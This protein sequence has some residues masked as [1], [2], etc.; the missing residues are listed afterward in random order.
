[1][2]FA[3]IKM[4][5]EKAY[6]LPVGDIH[7]GDKA[8]KKVGKEKLKAN[9]DWLEEHKDHAFGVIMGDVFN[10]AGRDT[11][12]TP[13][14][15]DSDEYYE[16]EAFF[17]PYAHLFVGAVRGNHEDRL[18]NMYGFDPL[19]LFCNHLNIPYFG[20]AALL[21]IQVGKRPDSNWFWNSYY[22]MV[23]HT[24]GGGGS[25]G[26]A[27]EKVKKLERIMPGCDVYAGGHTHQLVTGV[28]QRFTP[29]PTGPKMV[30]V[31]YVVT[32][33]YLDYEGSYAE[34]HMMEPG[35]LGSPRIRFSGVRD[36]RDIHISV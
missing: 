20:P 28:S 8:F 5:A 10:V 17:K 33:S 30:K 34:D 12:T 32:G 25:L 24:S 31:H 22:M 36:H 14:E 7:W 21:R 16:A 3:E 11:K 15:S 4:P 13:F 35:K 23:H 18:R 9:L 29:T 26:G 6:C 19:K 2:D 27:L 1:M